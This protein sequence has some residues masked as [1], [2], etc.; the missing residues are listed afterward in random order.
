M[1]RMVL[2][3]VTL[4]ACVVGELGEDEADVGAIGAS[5]NP[6]DRL[7]WSGLSSNCARGQN[8]I[9]ANGEALSVLFDQG[10]AWRACSLR[11]TLR[12]PANVRLTGL[13][14][15]VRTAGSKATIRY[16][17]NVNNA[18]VTSKTTTER[19]TLDAFA[20]VARLGDVLCRQP[21]GGDRYVPISFSVA[22]EG[23]GVALDSVD[24]AFSA[25]DCR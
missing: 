3:L 13:T 2:V 7:V 25:A 19:G 22:V 24:W 5:S 21:G 11:G 14:Q 15:Q 4:S 6:G 12:V 10:T 18:Q 8:S 1:K 17:A 9:V 20:S 16:N 23:T